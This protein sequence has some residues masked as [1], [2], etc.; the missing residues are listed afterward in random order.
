[1]QGGVEVLQGLAPLAFFDPHH[2]AGVVVGDHGEVLVAAAIGDLVH[3]DPIQALEPVGVDMVSHDAAH[4]VVDRFPAAAQ[5]RGGGRLVGPLHQ[6]G[7]HVFEVAGVAGAGPSPG[8]LFGAD[9]PAP[10]AIE[11]ADV[12]FDPHP[13]HACVQV[14]PPAPSG[15]VAGPGRP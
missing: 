8:D 6:P 15:V 2:S 1:A 9:P 4:D 7:D 13:A 12:A 5:Q 14:P 11:P 10:A 3:P